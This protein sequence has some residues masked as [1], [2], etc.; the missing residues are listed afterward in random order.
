MA[1]IKQI[2]GNSGQAQV[3]FECTNNKDKVHWI[4]LYDP[5][6]VA[7]FATKANTVIMEQQSNIN[8]NEIVNQTKKPSV[9][10]QSMPYL[11]DSITTMSTII[12]IAHLNGNSP[13][14]TKMHPCEINN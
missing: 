2:D 10:H 14:I 3:S 12:T 7:A 1:E 5:N 8:M 6:E 13:I 4:H 11:E 9:Q